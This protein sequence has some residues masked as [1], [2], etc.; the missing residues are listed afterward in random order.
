MLLPAD[1]AGVPG[2]L[3]AAAP[4]PGTVDSEV[5]T[6]TQIRMRMILPP[7]IT[8]DL[9]E[10]LLL[11]LG[12]LSLRLMQRLCFYSSF[13]ADFI[14]LRRQGNYEIGEASKDDYLN[15]LLK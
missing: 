7:E 3:A 1:V 14:I 5:S 10:D 8:K 9:K 4:K 2:A 11:W 13:S 6:I 15:N 12:W